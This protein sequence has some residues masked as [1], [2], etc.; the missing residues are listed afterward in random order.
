MQLIVFDFAHLWGIHQK[1]EEYLL[2][3]F[4][5]SN[6]FD[7]V[8]FVSCEG[9]L[10]FCDVVHNNSAIGIDPKDTCAQ[11]QYNSLN[12]QRSFLA[13]S[14]TKYPSI[15]IDQVSIKVPDTTESNS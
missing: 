5:V 6:C 4:L 15:A 13:K 7:S 1:H 9:D 2:E 11:C 8:L 12:Y 3:S 10:P 14:L